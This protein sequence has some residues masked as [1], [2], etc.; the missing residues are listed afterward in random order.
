MAA[1]SYS[2]K[3]EHSVSP[4]Q[5]WSVFSRLEKWFLG[6]PAV[7]S[8]R[9]IVFPWQLKVQYVF[10]APR[11]SGLMPPLHFVS[12]RVFIYRR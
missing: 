6:L 10:S 9:N 5:I 7:L 2:Q 8:P 12:G 11:Q 3:E 4:R 1:I